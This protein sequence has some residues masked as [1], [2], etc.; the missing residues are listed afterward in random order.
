MW[1]NVVILFEPLIDDRLGLSGCWEPL[2]VE[3]F[4][5]QGSVKALIITILPGRARID[6]DW[7]DA[8]FDEPV[9]EGFGWIAPSFLD[10][11]GT[12]FLPSLIFD[13]RQ[14]PVSYMLTLRIIDNLDIIEHIPSSLVTRFVNPAVNS[15]S[16]EQIEEAAWLFMA[17]VQFLTRRAATYCI[18]S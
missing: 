12:Y 1:P 16:F 9:F 14:H 13:R 8:D 15:L 17:S 2:S 3:N 11:L 7:L 18:P 10:T 4:T 6:V 5:T